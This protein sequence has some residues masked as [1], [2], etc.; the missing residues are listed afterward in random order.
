MGDR[1]GLFGL[2]CFI[3]VTHR[4]IFVFHSKTGGGYQQ[5]LMHGV[6]VQGLMGPRVK[7]ERKRG[8]GRKAAGKGGSIGSVGPVGSVKKSRASGT[9]VCSVC[10]FGGESASIRSLLERTFDN[11]DKFFRELN[12]LSGF[13]FGNDAGGIVCRPVPL[14]SH[15][16]EETNFFFERS[17]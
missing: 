2:G 4:Q 3:I 16:L 13:H 8:T 12:G 17:S 6:Q 5:N 7:R 9:H 11:S 14:H 10:F 15:F 1:S